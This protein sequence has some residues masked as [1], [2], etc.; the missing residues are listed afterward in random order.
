[1]IHAFKPDPITNRQEAWR[2][3]DFVQHHPEALHVVTWVKSPWGIPANYRQ[4]EGSSV[5]TY[6]L[7][8][9]QG[10]AHLAKFSWVP[11]QGVKNLTSAEA[12]EIQARDVGHATQDLYDAIERGDFPEWEFCVQLMTDDAHDELD[13]DRWTT[14]SVGPRI[15]SRCCRS[16]AWC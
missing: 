14:P 6:K 3:F 4:M 12:A 16:A 7:V 1:M 8:N 10:V 15:S 5:N 13:F 2:F 9:D 11:K